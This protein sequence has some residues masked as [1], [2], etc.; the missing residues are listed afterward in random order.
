MKLGIYLNAQH[1]AGDDPARRFAE[2]VEQARLIHSLGFDSIWGGEHHVT[3]GFHYFPLLPMLQRL[4][5]EVPGLE[6]GTNLVLL[7]LHNPVEIA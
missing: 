5:A 4:A 2:T 1:P 3:P 6:I 7:P